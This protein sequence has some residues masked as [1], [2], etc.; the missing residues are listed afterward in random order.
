MHP[1][2]ETRRGGCEGGKLVSAG[3]SLKAVAV[4]ELLSGE[5]EVERFAV[6]AGL[7]TDWSLVS[8]LRK[9]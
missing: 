6:K 7:W 2:G 1:R 4:R 5:A 8:R 3:H 9:Y